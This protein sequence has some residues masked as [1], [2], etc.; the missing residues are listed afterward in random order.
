[1]IAGKP[2]N[3]STANV[4][5]GLMEHKNCKKCD[6]GRMQLHGQILLQRPAPAKVKQ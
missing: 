5:A 3:S 6:N 4:V 1:M 2:S